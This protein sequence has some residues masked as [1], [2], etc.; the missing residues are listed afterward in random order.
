VILLR[1]APATPVS[2]VSLAN[3]RCVP[4]SLSAIESRRVSVEVEV[5]PLQESKANP[6]I[7]DA[8]GVFLQVGPQ[9]S[10]SESQ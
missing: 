10:Q 4:P 2:F 6:S 5:G 8:K 9:S 7:D 3:Q 1:A